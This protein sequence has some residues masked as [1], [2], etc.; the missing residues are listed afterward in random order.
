[1]EDLY[2]EKKGVLETKQAQRNKEIDK[3]EFKL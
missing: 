1:M 2:K 3:Y